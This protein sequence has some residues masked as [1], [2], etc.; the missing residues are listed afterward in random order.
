LI[1]N[2]FKDKVELELMVSGVTFGI[3]NY[4]KCDHIAFYI[5]NEKAEECNYRKYLIRSL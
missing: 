1:L 4:M 5:F 2:L 3:S